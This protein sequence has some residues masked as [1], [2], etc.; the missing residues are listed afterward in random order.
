MPVGQQPAAPPLTGDCA[1]PHVGIADPSH[2]AIAHGCER[3]LPS[4][5]PHSWTHGSARPG[6]AGADP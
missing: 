2:I 5:Q 6:Q 3:L 1:V 4:R